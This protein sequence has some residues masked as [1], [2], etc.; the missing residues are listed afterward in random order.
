MEPLA[1][2]ALA[3]LALEAIGLYLTLRLIRSFGVHSSAM[4]A[5]RRAAEIL[6]RSNVQ[7]LERLEELKLE[8][9]A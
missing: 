2:I 1:W 9:S 5:Q 8:R 4:H 3:W 7:I 6:H